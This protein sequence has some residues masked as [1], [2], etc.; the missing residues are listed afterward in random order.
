MKA[1]TAEGCFGEDDIK[2]MVFTT[3]PDIFV[4]SAFSPNGDGLNDVLRPV[5]VGISKI[6]MFRI[7]NRWGQLVFSA[8]DAERGWDGTVNGRIQTTGNFVYMVQGVDYTGRTIV[9]K[10]II[11]I[12]Q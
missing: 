3:A 8:T 5:G 11:T 2:V 7:Y 9:K 10:G 6:D 12:I 1:A 4:P